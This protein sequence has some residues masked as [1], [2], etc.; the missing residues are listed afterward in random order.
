MLQNNLLKL[1]KDSGD[2]PLN[3]PGSPESSGEAEGAEKRPGPPDALDPQIAAARGGPGPGSP[4]GAE[5]FLPRHLRPAPGSPPFCNDRTEMNLDEEC[6]DQATSIRT[7]TIT[8]KAT[9]HKALKTGS[10]SNGSLT[11]A[12]WE[13]YSCNAW[14]AR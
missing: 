13:I 6:C 12:N 1:Q 14:V 9:Q 3:R 7:R 10:C 11:G 8:C 4:V 5:E 2:Q